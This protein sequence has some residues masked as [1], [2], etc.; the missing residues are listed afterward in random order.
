MGHFKKLTRDQLK[1]RKGTENEIL[2]FWGISKNWENV[3]LRVYLYI[4]S[5]NDTD[6]RLQKKLSKQKILLSIRKAFNNLT[7]LSFLFWKFL[8]FIL[9]KM[10][11]IFVLYFRLF[12]IQDSII[13]LNESWN[14]LSCESWKMIFVFFFHRTLNF[15]LW[16][17]TDRAYFPKWT[18]LPNFVG[19]DL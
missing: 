14:N 1:I 17:L 18:T 10:N 4:W 7:Y 6:K 8:T 5:P 12:R 15:R 9:L 11:Q 13:F 19:F 2:L 3:I 16:T